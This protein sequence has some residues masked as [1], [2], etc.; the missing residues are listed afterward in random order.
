[1]SEEGFDV[2]TFENKNFARLPG[3]VSAVVYPDSIKTLGMED[4]QAQIPGNV[5]KA[6]S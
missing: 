4:L 6:N 3:E 5:R 1:M 2:I